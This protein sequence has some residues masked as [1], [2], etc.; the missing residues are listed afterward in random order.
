MAD[1]R[2]VR[3]SFDKF[4]NEVQIVGIRVPNGKKYGRGYIEIKGQLFKVE[5][6]DAQKEGYQAWVRFTKLE[7]RERRGW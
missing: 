5:V 7:E 3:T 1:E 2:R 4:G 6:T